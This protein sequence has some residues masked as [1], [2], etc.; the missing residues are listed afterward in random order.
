MLERPSRHHRWSVPASGLAI[1]PRCVTD[2]RSE[3]VLTKVHQGLSNHLALVGAPPA[4]T[5]RRPDAALAPPGLDRGLT[6]ES[7]VT[8]SGWGQRTT[9]TV[10]GRRTAR[11]RRTRRVTTNLADA[12][13]VAG[14]R[15]TRRASGSCEGRRRADRVTP[16]PTNVSLGPTGNG[17]PPVTSL[18]RRGTTKEEWATAPR[19]WPVST[20]SRRR[21]ELAAPE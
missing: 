7:G 21:P 17:G 2:H 1:A 15:V 19:P 13:P 18:V 16:F 4:I 6:G 11:P 5:R 9:A 20:P 3:S 10:T 12:P 8:A 14:N